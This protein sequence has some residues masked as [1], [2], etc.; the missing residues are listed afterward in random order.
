M[1]EPLTRND[2]AD[3]LE[4]VFRVGPASG[5]QIELTLQQVSELGSCPGHETFS[6]ILHGPAEKMLQQ[7]IYA[8][9]HDRLG[10]QEIFIVPIARNEQ[11]ISYE[12]IFNRLVS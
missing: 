3:C 6:I 4:S 1:S 12:A 9:E 7:G 8:F 5:D 2:F 10:L 11:G